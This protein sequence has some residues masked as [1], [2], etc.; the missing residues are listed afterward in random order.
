MAIQAKYSASAGLQTLI[1]GSGA[2]TTVLDLTNDITLRASK[3]GDSR[4]GNTFKLVCAAAA[5]NDA[6]N[7]EAVVK[8]A[9]TQTAAAI[10][11]TVTPDST[12]A[13]TIT[14]AEVAEMINTG[15]VAGKNI[16]ITDPLNLRTLQSATGGGAAV[17]AN[18]GEVGGAGVIGTF[19]GAPTADFHIG[20]A[21]LST[22]VETLTQ[23]VVEITCP[24]ANVAGF[25]GTTVTLVDADGLPN[26]YVIQIAGVPAAV[27]NQIA[28]NFANDEGDAD[29]VAAAFEGVIDDAVGSHTSA[30]VGAVITVTNLKPGVALAPVVTGTAGF[31]AVVTAAGSGANKGA[32]SLHGVTIIDTSA[33]CALTLADA[34]ADQAGLIKTVVRTAAGNA[35]NADLV[36]A[37][38]VD[39]AGG[40]NEKLRF[41]AGGEKVSM[42]WLGSTWAN[43]GTRTA[44]QA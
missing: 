17:L 32:L 22:D 10:L 7:A 38:H 9:F 37:K 13:G 5:D 33:A 26:E 6:A 43:I 42:I 40:N 31:T 24:R 23:Q 18:G 25:A 12:P 39:G 34:P 27:G 4:N 28:V 36:I 35:T 29:A 1:P 44:T 2:A 8:V 14:T 30:A 20:G 41:D 19:A 15:A 11:C 21:G 3:D 16:V